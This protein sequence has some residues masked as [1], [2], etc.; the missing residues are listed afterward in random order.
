MDLS[1]LAISFIYAFCLESAKF[2]ISVMSEIDHDTR[3][4]PY[5]DLRQVKIPPAFGWKGVQLVFL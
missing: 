2:D 1:S 3:R 4:V 5:N